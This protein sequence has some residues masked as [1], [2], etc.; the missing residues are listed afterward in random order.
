MAFRDLGY[1]GISTRDVSPSDVASRLRMDK[2]TVRLRIKKMED[3]GF[4]KYYQATP[5]L[6]LFGLRSQGLYRFDAM[7]ITTKYGVLEHTQGLPGVVEVFDY[8]G[9]TI[10]V[11]IAGASS[12]N[13]QQLADGI[14]ARFELNKLS[15]GDRS[16]RE[17]HSR[18]D[19]L[20]WQIISKLRY[21]ARCS[22]TEVA[23]ALSIT[24]R[25][26]G[27]RIDKLL[28]SGAV[29]L[30]AVINTQ[31]QEGLIFYELGISIDEQRR[32][33]ISRQLEEKFQ[34]KLW[35]MR[36]PAPGF[37]LANLFGF[38]LAEPEEAAM[39]LT[40]AEGVRS[41]SISILKEVIEPVRPNWIDALIQKEIASARATQVER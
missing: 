17:R 15:L 37:L 6:A 35:S 20:D 38:T 3:T 19:R 12:I 18:P 32:G 41:C 40:K 21:D 23:D 16:I 36:L 28:D 14:A 39:Q 29:F 27:Y 11:S 4:I 8:L 7:N 34:A 33:T 26:A 2:K 22:S 25:M 9:P 30:R 31:K 24:P 1:G 13:V 5:D 10:S